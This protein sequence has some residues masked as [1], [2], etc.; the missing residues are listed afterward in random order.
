MKKLNKCKWA[1]RLVTHCVHWNIKKSPLRL[2]SWEKW[3]ST[4]EVVLESLFKWKKM[5]INPIKDC[6][7]EYCIYWNTGSINETSLWDACWRML[8]DLL[9]DDT[10]ISVI[11]HGSHGHRSPILYFLLIFYC[12]TI[13]S[14]SYSCISKW[15]HVM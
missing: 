12:H 14:L 3:S 9:P 10:F 6:R 2:Q 4:G 5:T 11:V 15:I 13:T 8:I 1:I 7:V